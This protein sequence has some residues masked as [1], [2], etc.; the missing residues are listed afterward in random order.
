M[1]P[2][3]QLWVPISNDGSVY[4]TH[5]VASTRQSILFVGNKKLVNRGWKSSNQRNS[6]SAMDKAEGDSGVIVDGGGG[7]DHDGANVDGEGVTNAHVL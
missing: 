6:L 1:K 4:F 2:D 5:G 3:N 7:K